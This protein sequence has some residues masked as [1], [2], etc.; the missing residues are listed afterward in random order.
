MLS[1]FASQGRAE[2]LAERP[3]TADAGGA[4]TIARFSRLLAVGG[5]MTFGFHPE[6]FSSVAR[7]ENGHSRRRRARRQKMSNPA[8]RITIA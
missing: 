8:A 7:A 5:R 2:D 1:S 6:A 4:A 3:G